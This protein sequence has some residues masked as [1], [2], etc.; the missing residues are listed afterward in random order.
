MIPEIPCWMVG[1][2]SVLFYHL[3]AVAPVARR[4]KRECVEMLEDSE[5]NLMAARKITKRVA[6]VEEIL[7]AHKII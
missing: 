3:V 5:K 2:M 4:L 7:R 1:V 6:E